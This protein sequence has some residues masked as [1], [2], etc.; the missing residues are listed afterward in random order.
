MRHHHFPNT[1]QDPD[2]SDSDGSEDLPPS[3]SQRKRESTALQ[4]MGAELVALSRDQLKKIDLPDNLRTAVRDCQRFTSHG[5][6]SRQMQYIGKL[7]R[8]IDPAPIQAA[9][10]EIK[11]VSAAANARQH[12]LERLR[13]RLLEDEA[14]LGEIARDYPGTDITQ[15]RQLRRNALKEQEHNKPPRA[16]REIFRVLRDLTENTKEAHDADDAGAAGE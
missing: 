14:V 9:L 4:D 12:A 11:G 13:T 6:I 16:F 7:M 8:S 10:D 2:Q 5:A 15:L 3:K 1:S